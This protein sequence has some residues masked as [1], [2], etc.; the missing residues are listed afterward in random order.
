V[1]E[2]GKLD[3]GDDGAVD[4]VLSDDALTALA[5]SADVSTPLGEDAVPIDLGRGVEGALLPSWYMPPVVTVLHH[6]AWRPLV[7]VLVFSFLFI[8]CAGLCSTYGQL[9]IP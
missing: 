5:L 9:V 7:M 4:T 2:Y 6:R 1:E 8:E 3:A